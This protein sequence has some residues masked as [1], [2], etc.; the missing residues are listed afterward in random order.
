MIKLIVILVSLFA[1]SHPVF[2]A[3]ETNKVPS[4]IPSSSASSGAPP[5]QAGTSEVAAASFSSSADG[6]RLRDPFWPIGFFPP[7]MPGGASDLAKSVGSGE[8]KETTN[9][10][11]NLSG[12]LRIGG[13]IRKGNKFYA[14]INGFTVQTGEVVSV[15]SGGE[16][17]KFIVEGIDFNKVQFKPVKSRE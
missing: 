6:L 17:Y 16:I 4:A 12:M 13:V 3:D 14:T 7:S 5:R 2:P 1:V 11:S 9:P 15:I 10:A 8:G